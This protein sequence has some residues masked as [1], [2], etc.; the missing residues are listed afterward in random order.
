MTMPGVGTATGRASL[1][2]GFFRAPW[3]R[4]TRA[5][6]PHMVAMAAAG[7]SG[8]SSGALVARLNKKQASFGPIRTSLIANDLA[9]APEHYILHSA[10]R[11]GCLH[12][13]PE[14]LGASLSVSGLQRTQVR[15]VWC[16]QFEPTRSWA[17][18]ISS[19]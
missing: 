14:S 13:A 4:A 5:G 2:S 6:Q 12:R 16:A 8:S 7:D 1:D 3:D 17:C 19:A 10:F 15:F 11:D 18:G 9:Y